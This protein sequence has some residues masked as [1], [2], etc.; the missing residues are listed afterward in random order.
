MDS[1]NSNSTQ[2]N[3]T[4]ATSSKT[5]EE[6]FNP[7]WIYVTKLEKTREGGGCVIFVDK[8]SKGLILE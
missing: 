1:L 5:R 7:L 6:E 4:S 8:K 3:R 2:G